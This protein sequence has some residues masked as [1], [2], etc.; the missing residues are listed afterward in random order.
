ME[1]LLLS[2]KLV[3]WKSVRE[4]AVLTAAEEALAEETTDK[5]FKK[6]GRLPLFFYRFIVLT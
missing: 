4:Q 1:E 5:L 2:M 3:R 6:Q